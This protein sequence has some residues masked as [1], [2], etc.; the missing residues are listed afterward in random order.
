MRN[1]VRSFSRR[2]NDV[3]FANRSTKLPNKVQ[4]THGLR[5][6]ELGLTL[7]ALALSSRCNAGGKNCCSQVSAPLVMDV[8]LVMELPLVIG[9]PLVMGVP[10]MMDVPLVMGVPLVIPLVVPLRYGPACPL[11]NAS[12]AGLFSTA[13]DI[14]ALAALCIVAR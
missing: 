12:T 1:S 10:L 3:T 4:W 6:D 11:T 14:F 9:I 8:P 5:I 7:I 2:V 13:A